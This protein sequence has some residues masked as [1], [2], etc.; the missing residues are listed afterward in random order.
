METAIS[1]AMPSFNIP[2]SL[3]LTFVTGFR[4]AISLPSFS[5][6][7]KNLTQPSLDWLPID[8]LEKGLDVICSLQ[9]I[10]NHKG[11]FKD[12]HD[13]DGGAAR[14]M[15]DI[16]FID[17]EVIQSFGNIILIQNCPTDA[18]HRPR[19]LKLLFPGF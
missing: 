10:I 2:F 15:S 19:C 18:S 7:E 3:S 14:R 4:C 9:S 16:V 11:M 13:E 5:C 12:I 6:F 8:V 17:P 1:L